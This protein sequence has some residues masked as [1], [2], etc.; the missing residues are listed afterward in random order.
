[1]TEIDEYTK[2][3]LAKKNWKY[4]NSFEELGYIYYGPMVFNFFIWLKQNISES[5]LILF[6]SRE[7]YFLNEIYEIFKTRYSLS[8]SVYFKTSRKIAT[9]S[10]IYKESDIYDTF[11]QHRFQG[12]MSK[13]LQNRF[14]IKVDVKNDIY[15]D[16]LKQIPDLSEY[17]FDILEYCK[18][19]RIEYGDYISNTIKDYKN[20][21]MVDTGF[22]GTIQSNLQKAYNFKCVGRYFL[23]KENSSLVDVKGFFDFNL[24]KLKNNLVFLESVFIDQVGSY[25]DIKD[26]KFINEETQKSFQYFNQKVKIIIGIKNFVNDMLQNEQLDLNECD[27]LYSDY[28]FDTMCKNNFV[29]ND[30]LFDIFYHDNYYVRETTKKLKRI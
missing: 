19:L 14:S 25:T 27:Y 15:V 10:A 16:S 5:D 7:G 12:S 18:R 2:T 3:L 22:Q 21:L 24:S 23:Y 13:L 8:K 11:K 9:N 4:P 17:I 28:I 26:G 30:S 29:T 6:N 1:M 20:I